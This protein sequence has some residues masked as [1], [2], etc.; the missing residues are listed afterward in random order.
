M[1][2]TRGMLKGQFMVYQR[3]GYIGTGDKEVPVTNEKQ[4]PLLPPDVEKAIKEQKEKEEI[5]QDLPNP[6]RQAPLLPPFI[7]NPAKR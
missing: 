6:K 1:E 3:C 2:R 7:I 5:K 4:K